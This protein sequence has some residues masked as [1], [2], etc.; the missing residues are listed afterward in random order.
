ME[1][2][3]LA[4]ATDATHLLNSPAIEFLLLPAL[5][6]CLDFTVAKITMAM[7][8]VRMRMMARRAPVT[9]RNTPPDTA[10][11]EDVLTAVKKWYNP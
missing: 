4:I 3:E 10:N 7:M 8:K 11:S 5:L 6:P 2:F 1:K 9:A